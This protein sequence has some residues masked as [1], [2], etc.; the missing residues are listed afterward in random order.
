LAI[1]HLSASSRSRWRR[2]RRFLWLRLRGLVP[3]R[4]FARGRRR[5][6]FAGRRARLPSCA[7]RGPE[8]RRV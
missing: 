7:V 2:R 1:S 6:A 4:A 3:R 8:F 5:R